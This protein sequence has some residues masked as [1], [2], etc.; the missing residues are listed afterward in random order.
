MDKII[1]FAFILMFIIITT[2]VVMTVVPGQPIEQNPY[3]PLLQP[4][5][6]SN[7][8]I[9]HPGAIPMPKI[10]AERELI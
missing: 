6:Y 5:R 4:G 9:N 3:N 8:L 7:Y 10:I 1:N 2:L